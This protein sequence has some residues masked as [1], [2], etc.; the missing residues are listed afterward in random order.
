M[1]AKIVLA[2]DLSPAWDEIIAC[3]GELKVLGCREIVLMHVVTVKF[4]GGFTEQIRAEAEPK[5][6][7]QAERLAAQGFTVCRE[8]PLGLPAYAI[9]DAAQRHCAD[10]IVVGP[11]KPSR[12]QERILGSVAGAVLHRA[13]AP[14]LFLKTGIREGMA[15]G[16]CRLHATELLRHVLFP[17][18]FSEISERAGACLER[19]ADRRL[20]QVTVLHALDVPGGD[21]YPPGFQE[22]AVAQTQAALAAWEERLRRAGIP[23]V[24]TVFDPGRPLPAILQVLESQDI[25]LIVMGAQG[26]G[27]IRELFLGSV[28]HN[29]A[30]L[31]PCPV[32]L[33]PPGAR[34]RGGG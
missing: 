16:A 12:W 33:T 34:G 22:M 18:D 29:V 6:A 31:A 17:T 27:F 19:L 9:N 24:K 30:R 15:P 25:S 2:T 7:A 8:M 20:A 23:R 3:A 21:A 5:L 10:L 1:F 13:E 32:L 26:K 28:A 14:V 11:Q 4:L